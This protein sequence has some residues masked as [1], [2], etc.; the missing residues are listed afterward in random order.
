MIDLKTFIDKLKDSEALKRKKAIHPPINAFS[1]LWNM[2]STLDPIGDDA[3]IIKLDDSYLL[4]SCDGILP[5]LVKE[6]PFWAG[7][8]AVL[9]SVSDIY[10]M[11]GRPIALVNLL[12]APDEEISVEIANGMAEGC[13]KLGVPMVGGHFF[14]KESHGVATAILGKASHLLRATEGKSG[15]SLLAAIDLNGKPFKHYPQWNS[16][17][18]LTPKN[19]QRKLE[20]LPELA[21]AGLVTAARDISNAGIVGTV[22]MLAEN[23]NH[24]ATIDLNHIPKPPSVSMEDWLHFYPGYGFILTV[25]K[26]DEEE[27]KFR[28]EKEGIT[29]NIIGELTNSLQVVVSSGEEEAVYFDLNNNSLV[30]GQHVR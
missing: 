18:E 5:Q 16:T 20:I 4:L 7:Y 24:G 30:V 15:Q 22:A 25:N 14:P 10:A 12:S 27:V 9:V 11:G 21:E 26:E 1:N 29:A 17:S 6:E 2:G 13:R 8:C 3:G 23:S 19:M 28:F